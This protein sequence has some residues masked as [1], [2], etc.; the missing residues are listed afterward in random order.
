MKRLLP[1]CLSTLAL[2]ST[3]RAEDNTSMLPAGMKGNYESVQAPIEKIYTAEHDG[4]KF[5]AF[6]VKWHDQEVV[7]TNMLGQGG[8]KKVGDKINFMAQELEMPVMGRTIKMIQFIAMDSDAFRHMTGSFDDKGLKQNP[9]EEKPSEAK[10][11]PT[12]DSH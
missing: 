5:Q 6:V 12:P 7:V 9:A 11:S 8:E 10:P 3:L 4:F 2:V 1:L